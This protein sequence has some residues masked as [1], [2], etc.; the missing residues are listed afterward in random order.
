MLFRSCTDSILAPSLFRMQPP[1]SW[2]QGRA[3]CT[4]AACQR[5]GLSVN[6]PNEAAVKID[7]RASQNCGVSPGNAS[8][9]APGSARLF[10]RL[11]VCL[12]GRKKKV[13]SQS[14]LINYIKFLFLKGICVWLHGLM[15]A[16]LEG[17]ELATLAT[18]EGEWK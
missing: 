10:C 13:L 6:S 5:G 15:V 8:V 14:H 7:A 1:K 12:E 11:S 3:S 2:P 18:W 16:E 9:L 4:D 17:V